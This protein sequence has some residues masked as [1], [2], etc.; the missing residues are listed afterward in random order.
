MPTVLRMFPRDCSLCRAC[1]EAR[2]IVSRAQSRYDAA[3]L[4]P[5]VWHEVLEAAVLA[6][7][8]SL[9]EEEAG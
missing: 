2:D 1:A 9:V 4:F 7:F 3:L 8:E 5:G 6:T